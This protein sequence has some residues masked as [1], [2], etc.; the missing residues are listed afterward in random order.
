MYKSNCS[1]PRINQKNRTAVGNINA[2]KHVAIDSDDRVDPR[3][4]GRRSSRHDS[5]FVAM[6]LLSQP[7]LARKKSSSDALVI[8]V[9]PAKSGRS[10]ASDIEAG[11]SQRKAVQ[12]KFQATEGRKKLHRNVSHW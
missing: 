4:F 2:Q 11:D 10:I 9:Q 12:N 5:D 6:N 1:L 3:A 8:R 7:G